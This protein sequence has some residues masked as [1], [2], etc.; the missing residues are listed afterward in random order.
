MEGYIKVPKGIPKSFQIAVNP[1]H[2]FAMRGTD[3]NYVVS[4]IEQ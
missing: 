3:G 1:D 2:K 4:E